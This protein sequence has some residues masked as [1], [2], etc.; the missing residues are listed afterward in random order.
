MAIHKLDVFK[1][2]P[3]VDVCLEIIATVTKA[4]DA[5]GF[6]RVLFDEEGVMYLNPYDDAAGLVSLLECDATASLSEDLLEHFRDLPGGHRVEIRDVAA[7][8]LYGLACDEC[9]GKICDED[10]FDWLWVIARS[11]S[12]LAGPRRPF[13]RP[14]A[15]GGHS[16]RR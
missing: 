12:P 4:A 2:P 10:G 14:R 1:E 13:D 6:P 11:I 7:G 9:E 5:F 8:I 15:A 16:P 3:L